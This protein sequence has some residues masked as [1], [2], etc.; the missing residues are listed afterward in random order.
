[1]QSLYPIRFRPAL[2]ETLWGGSTLS[3][4]F[5]RRRRRARI[6]ESWEITG[7]PGASPWQ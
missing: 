3:R 6:G 4:R 5:G 7:M 2:K 1:M